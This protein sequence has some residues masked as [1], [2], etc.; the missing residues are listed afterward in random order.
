MKMVVNYMQSRDYRWKASGPADEPPKAVA[1]PS[2]AIGEWL[3][4]ATSNGA[5]FALSLWWMIK[6][7]KGEDYWDWL[8]PPS[9]ACPQR[10]FGATASVTP[11]HGAGKGVSQLIGLARAGEVVAKIQATMRAQAAMDEMGKFVVADRTVT[12]ENPALRRTMPDG[13]YADLL[14]EIP[15]TDGYYYISIGNAGFNKGKGFYHGTA[16]AIAGD[17]VRY[18][19]PNFGECTELLKSQL[20]AFVEHLV[21]SQ[22]GLPKSNSTLIQAIRFT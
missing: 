3:P 21:Y 20:L 11:T 19:D 12:A 2:G 15:L 13:G 16:C 14:D 22:Y 6:N 10:G 9:S 5:C 4:T 7:S 17:D 8:G 1:N 18:F